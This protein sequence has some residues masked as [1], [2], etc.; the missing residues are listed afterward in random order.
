MKIILAN[1]YAV[2]ITEVDFIDIITESRVPIPNVHWKHSGLLSREEVT[3]F[4]KGDKDP[5]EMKK[6]A[7]YILIYAENLVFSACLFNKAQGGNPDAPKEFGM[8]KV[9]RLKK[10]YQKVLRSR[11]SMPNVYYTVNEML[12]VCSEI[13]ID[14][15]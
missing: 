5:G 12:K 15:F 11:Q 9:N 7:R 2:E 8:P 6:L 1:A 4:L 10:L 13:G 3:R 14:P